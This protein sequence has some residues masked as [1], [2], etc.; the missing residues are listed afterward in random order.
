MKKYIKQ[1]LHSMG[2]TLIP[3]KPESP[4]G[5]SERP[6]GNI[7]TFLEDIKA[8]GFNPGSILDI[9]ANQGDW[10]RMAKAVFPNASFFLM[11]PQ[12]EMRDPLNQLCSEFEDISW[13]E[14]GAGSRGGKLV[15]TIWDDLQ[16]SS[17][18][19]HVDEKLL[20]TGKQRE[21]DIITI[22]SLLE[23]HNLKT[24]DLVK[25]DIQGFELE[26]LSG[27]TT[28]FGH[29]EIFI[30][31]VSLFSFNDVPGM[32]ILRE[33]VDFMGERGYE[34]YDIPGFLRRPFD[35]ALGQVDLAFAK[36]KGSL[37][38]SNEFW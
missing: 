37:R 35:G 36:S 19:P 27:A 23:S 5:S 6:I 26:A 24:P 32:P 34:T 8:R 38:Q 17:F 16:G 21:V 7:K 3:Y 12:Q 20:Q 1:I 9:G 15:Q 30:L 10:T 4:Q 13:I 14:A 22:D 25:L 29:T 11:E 33:V 28:L 2:Y 31:E 18:L